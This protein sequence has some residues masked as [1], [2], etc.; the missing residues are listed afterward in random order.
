MSIFQS[1]IIEN[2]SKSSIKMTIFHS[3][4]NLPE[5][6]QQQSGAEFALWNR[7]PTSDPGSIE[8]PSENLTSPWKRTIICRCFTN[9]AIINGDFE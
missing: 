8:L 5:G 2:H 7:F 1:Y 4:I 9:L 3:Y 6:K